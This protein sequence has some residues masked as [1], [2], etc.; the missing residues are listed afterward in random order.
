MPHG[1]IVLRNAWEAPV[2]AKKKPTIRLVYEKVVNPLFEKRP[3]Q[4]GTGGALSPKKELD[5]VGQVASCCSY[6]K[7]KE[8]SEATLEGPK[9]K[10]LRK[11]KASSKSTS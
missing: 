8:D 7:T 9:G 10:Q 6:S 4:F 3:K 1:L 11:E 5:W 2:L